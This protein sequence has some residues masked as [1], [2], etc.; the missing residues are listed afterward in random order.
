MRNGVL[1]FNPWQPLGCGLSLW[2]YFHIALFKLQQNEM[3]LKIPARIIYSPI[4][5]APNT[6]AESPSLFLIIGV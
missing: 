6:P 3:Q 1:I 5:A 2:A 4:Q